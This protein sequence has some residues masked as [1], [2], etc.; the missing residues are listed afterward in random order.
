MNM[1]IC[2][3]RGAIRL[4]V[5]IEGWMW[6]VL[7][8]GKLIFR[9]HFLRS[10]VQLWSCNT[11]CVRIQFR[12]QFMCAHDLLNSYIAYILF[13][14]CGFKDL[15]MCNLSTLVVW[16]LK[17]PSE[18]LVARCPNLMQGVHV[19]ACVSILSQFVRSLQS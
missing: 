8:S 11:L 1:M 3:H 19:T 17:Q 7:H 15:K 6:G 18:C 10:C 12:N 16:W 2:S 13:T 4:F 14:K 9:A 5:W